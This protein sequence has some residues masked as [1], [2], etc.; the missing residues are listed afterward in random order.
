MGCGRLSWLASRGGCCGFLVKAASVWCGSSSR[1]REWSGMCG[2]LS[3]LT[4][5]IMS[6]TTYRYHM[7]VPRVGT[8]CRYHVSVPCVGTTCRYHTLSVVACGLVL[9]P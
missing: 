9:C 3:I 5:S 1:R 8:T 4:N 6:G 7:S 2:R